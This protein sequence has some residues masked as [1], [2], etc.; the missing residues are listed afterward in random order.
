MAEHRESIDA[1]LRELLR[2][3]VAADAAH[4]AVSATAALLPKTRNELL[5]PFDELHGRSDD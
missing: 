2:A 1:S 4:A 3:L 5:P